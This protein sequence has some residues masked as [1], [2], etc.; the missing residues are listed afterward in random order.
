MKLAMT[1]ARSMFN[2]SKSGLICKQNNENLIE[3]VRL[4]VGISQ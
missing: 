2:H 4:G 3:N 1:G